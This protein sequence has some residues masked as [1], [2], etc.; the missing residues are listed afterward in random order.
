MLLGNVVGNVIST[1][2][3][4]SHEGKKLM[5]VEVIDINKKHTVYGR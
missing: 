4:S 5:I 3:T 2:K 1:I